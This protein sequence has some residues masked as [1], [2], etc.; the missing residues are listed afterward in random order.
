MLTSLR[1]LPLVV[2]LA[3]QVDHKEQARQFLEFCQA[4]KYAEASANFDAKMKEVLPPAK[5]E[6]TWSQIAQQLGRIEKMGPPRTD[7]V[8]GST[9][10]KIRCEFKS[11][12]LDAMVSFNSQGQ[13]EGFFL[14]P[15]V[16]TRGM[17]S[18]VV[19]DATRQ[20]PAEGGPAD[21]PAANRQL[22]VDGAPESFDLVRR[23]WDEYFQQ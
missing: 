9:R 19:I 7:H 5:L 3:G 1:W 10:V 14:D 6:Q 2:S 20:L 16:P 11:T 13:I 18:K 17:T 4:G 15:S 12:P 23:R 22:L 8:G 21:W